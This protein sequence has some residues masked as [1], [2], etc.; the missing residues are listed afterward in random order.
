MATIKLNRNTQFFE[1]LNRYSPDVNYYDLPS[2]LCDL[3]RETFF[4]VFA[5]VVIWG[6]AGG[7]V[8]MGI[9]GTIAF[10]LLGP[11][12]HWLLGIAGLLWFASFAL[13]ITLL[14]PLIFKSESV[15]P[16]IVKEAYQGLKDKYCPLVSWVE[17]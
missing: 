15:V 2:N 17:D 4:A 8:V 9:T 14:K 3:A 1:F 13:V 16:P 11:V 7:I 5:C 12:D 6:L 10:V